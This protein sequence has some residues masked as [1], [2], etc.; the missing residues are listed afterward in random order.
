MLNEKYR[1]ANLLVMSD[2]FSSPHLKFFDSS[3]RVGT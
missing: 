2:L 1:E 3:F